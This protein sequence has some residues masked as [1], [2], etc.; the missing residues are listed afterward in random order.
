MA[1]KVV[2]RSAEYDGLEL[3]LHLDSDD[4]TIRQVV[5]VGADEALHFNLADGRRVN[6][7]SE[8][9]QRIIRVLYLGGE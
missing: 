1:A 7:A 9:G 3:D 2:V 4:E 8:L 6:G 5:C